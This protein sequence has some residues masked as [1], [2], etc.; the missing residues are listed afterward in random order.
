MQYAEKT[1]RMGLAPRPGPGDGQNPGKRSDHSQGRAPA[2]R[3]EFEEEPFELMTAAVATK[4]RNGGE[5][6]K[7]DA[8]ITRILADNEN[9]KSLNVDNPL[10]QG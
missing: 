4:G 8:Y 9:L 2:R 10:T 3:P 7:V 6:D 1:A 5:P